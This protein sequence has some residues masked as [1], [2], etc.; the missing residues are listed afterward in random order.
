MAITF[1]YSVKATGNKSLDYSTED[2]TGKVKK[3][4]N[5]SKDSLEYVIRDKRGNVY[6]LSDAYL[7]KMKKYIYKDN[8][9]NIVFKTIQNTLNCSSENTYQEWE[10]IR[11]VMNPS[12]GS[13][14][15]LQYCIVQNFGTDVDPEIAN[16][17]GM[18]FAQEYLDRYQVV[19]STHINTG[20]VHNHIEFN[21]TSF[22]DGKKFN[23]QRKTIG[24]IRKI[25]DKFCKEY[26]LEVLEKTQEFNYVIYKDENGKTKIFEP[27]ERKLNLSENEFSNNDYR[28]SIAY[29]N[30]KKYSEMP[31]YKIVQHDMNNAIKISQNYE[32]MLQNLRNMGYIINDKTKNGEWRKRISFKLPEWDKPVRDTSLEEKYLRENLNKYFENHQAEKE[33]NDI[34]IND[35]VDDEEIYQYGRMI[36]EELNEKYRYETDEN[37]EVRKVDRSELEKMLIK[38]TKKVNREINEIVSQAVH[39]ERERIQTL[40][41]RTKKQQ[42]YIDIIN[43][44][45]KT[46]KFVEN[47]NLQSFKQISEKVS[48]LYDK[49]NKCYEQLKK[50]S[51]MMKK[52]SVVQEAV[53]QYLAL[54]DNI[55]KN[56]DNPDYQLYEMANDEMLL[57]EYSSILKKY[58][59]NSYEEISGYNQRFKEYRENFTIISKQLE[60]TNKNIMAYDSCINNI[61]R[62]DKEYS[63]IYSEQIEEYFREK[64]NYRRNDKER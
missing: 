30:S 15:N 62:V 13:S 8:E 48:V 17:I 42:Y 49:R 55:E 27:T 59:L 6:N 2:K 41:N 25:S 36:I 47:N 22:L 61:S 38:N 40:E 4:K 45:L 44:N 51:D 50:M 46:L 5:D 9:G 35:F 64:E 26:E 32:E 18:K 28:N 24:E 54:H 52:A 16:E 29:S 11:K 37:N 58:N 3:V 1:I 57:K 63:N 10:H 12:K 56:S 14:G 31:H 53:S 19:V 39:P 20:Y 23:D 33:S 7:E 60:D 43:N 34:G 21:A